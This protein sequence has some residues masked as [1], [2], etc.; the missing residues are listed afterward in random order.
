MSESTFEAGLTGFI[1][2]KTRREWLD[3]TVQQRVAA[4]ETTVLQHRNPHHDRR[5]TA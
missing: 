1:L 5:L 3:L 2:V 4:F